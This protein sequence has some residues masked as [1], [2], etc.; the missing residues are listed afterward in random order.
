[1]VTPGPFRRQVLDNH[2]GLLG[3]YFWGLYGKLDA[4]GLGRAEQVLSC[5]HIE[6]TIDFTPTHE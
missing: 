4:G 2:R 1:M 6:E 5:Q 3:T